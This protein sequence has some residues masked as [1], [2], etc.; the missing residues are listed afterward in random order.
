MKEQICHYLDE[1]PE[2]DTQVTLKICEIKLF[3]YTLLSF[4]YFAFYTLELY[5]HTD[6]LTFISSVFSV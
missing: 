5:M 4:Y 3:L 6:V 2:K 1:C